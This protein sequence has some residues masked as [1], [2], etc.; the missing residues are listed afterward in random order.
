MDPHFLYSGLLL[1]TGAFVGLASGFFGVGGGFL[2]VPIQYWGLGLIGVEP[3]TA[4]RTAF[5]TS[6]AVVL[7][8]A[9]SGTWAHHR[10]S[11][12]RW[13]TVYR[14]A[15]SAAV[16][17]FVG[18][19]ISTRLPAR[20]L[21][22]LLG[23]VLIALAARLA[24]RPDCSRDNEPIVLSHPQYILIGVTIGLLSGM[25]GIG[26]GVVLVPVLLLIL[27]YSVH[28][29]VGTSMPIILSA[30]IGGVT[31]YALNVPPDGPTLELSVGYV[32]LAGFLAL[33]ASSI[34]MAQVGARFAY[35]C[36]PRP[37]QLAFAGVMLIFGLVMINVPALIGA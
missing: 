24:R 4:L 35:A 7:P 19:M 29:A 1:L 6:L 13:E 17:S 18:G 30:A 3:E 8:T 9:A 12:I 14:M 5:G 11:A 15:P 27:H 22:L 20:P 37:L 32:H 34:P 31:S 33:A 10:R 26:G 16:F 36:S 25:L 21:E 2:M 23:V 28:A